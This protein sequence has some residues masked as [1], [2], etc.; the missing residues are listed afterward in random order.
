M[1]QEYRRKKT[2]VSKVNYHIVFC[3]RRRR[4]I[5]L[6]DGLDN[7]FKQLVKEICEQNDFDLLA[8]ETDK[9]HCH[10]FVNVPPDFSPAD[11]VR[12]IK[13]NTSRV[14]LSEYSHVIKAQT[15]WTRS[16]FVATAGDVSS[17]VIKKYIQEQRTR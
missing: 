9:D 10:I 5:F 2:S 11:V 1:N 16:Y 7:R 8:L 3:P 4:K 15:L 6:I 13:T 12:I 14:L 17:E